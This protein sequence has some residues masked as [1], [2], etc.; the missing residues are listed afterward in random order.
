MS[1][2]GVAPLDASPSA[3]VMMYAIGQHSYKSRSCN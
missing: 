3:W 2:M 1:K